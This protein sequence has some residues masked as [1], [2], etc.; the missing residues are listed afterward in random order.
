MAQWWCQIKKGTSE[1]LVEQGHFI[2]LGLQLMY[3][4][5]FNEICLFSFTFFIR[6]CSSFIH[7]VHM[8]TLSIMSHWIIYNFAG[9]SIVFNSVVSGGAFKITS[10]PFL[11]V[12]SHKL[13]LNKRQINQTD[14]NFI[15]IFLTQN[16]Q[17]LQ[18]KRMQDSSKSLHLLLCVLC[19]FSLQYSAF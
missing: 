4:S 8:I 12:I 16:N 9:I 7:L 11:H 6:K 3:S 5:L 18:V 19:M 10:I 14:T 15:I 2:Y 13:T 17:S 1:F